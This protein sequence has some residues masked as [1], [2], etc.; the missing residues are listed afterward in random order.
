MDSMASYLSLLQFHYR[1]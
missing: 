1:Q